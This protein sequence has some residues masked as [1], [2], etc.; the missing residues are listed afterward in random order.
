VFRFDYRALQRVQVTSVEIAY[1][2][3]YLAF[4]HTGTQRLP[5][6]RHNWGFVPS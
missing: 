2:P 6:A 4:C 3:S 5:V 1:P